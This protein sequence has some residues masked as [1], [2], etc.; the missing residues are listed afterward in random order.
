MHTNKHSVQ[1]YTRKHISEEHIFAKK[2][3]FLMKR[4]E[5]E[6]HPDPSIVNLPAA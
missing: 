6:I 2:Q 4:N 5:E 1:K 3:L